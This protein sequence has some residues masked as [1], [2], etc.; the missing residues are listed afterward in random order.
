[1]HRPQPLMNAFSAGSNADLTKED[2][3]LD[4][5]GAVLSKQQSKPVIAK[6]TNM[7]PIS[8]DIY[9]TSTAAVSKMTGDSMMRESGI[10]GSIQQTSSK[11]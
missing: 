3:N 9:G 5:D 1:M 2:Q 8:D 11:I 6:N 4:M 10:T 7:I